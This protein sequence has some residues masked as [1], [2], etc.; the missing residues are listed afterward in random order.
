MIWFTE[1]ATSNGPQKIV[2]QFFLD[3]IPEEISFGK[4]SKLNKLEYH[5]GFKTNQIIGTYPK[6]VEWSGTFEGTK[7]MPGGKQV[8]AKIRYDA[9]ESLVGRP[10]RVGFPSAGMAGGPFPGEGE[11][12]DN[13]T[14]ADFIGG[15]KGVYIIEELVPTVKNYWHID[16]KIRLVPH[17]RQEKIRPTETRQVLVEPRPEL[18]QQANDRINQRKPPV[19]GARGGRSTRATSRPTPVRNNGASSQTPPRGPQTPGRA[20]LDFL[21]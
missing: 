20:L 9:L 19:A 14:D 4:M 8:S 11:F 1:I 10:L 13:L 3:E 15:I 17:Q 7:T 5:G 16:Y 12:P 18:I 6:E 2:F 21:N